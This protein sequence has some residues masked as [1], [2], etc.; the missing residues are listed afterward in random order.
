MILAIGTGRSALAAL[1]LAILVSILWAPM[2]A[3]GALYPTFPIQ[4]SVIVAGQEMRLEWRDDGSSPRLDA[5][6][7]LTVNLFVRNDANLVSTL[8]VGIDPCD[9]V[10]LVEV[11][12]Y[13]GTDGD[14]YYIRYDPSN[15]QA[16]IYTANFRIEGL[17]GSPDY[18]Q[19]RGYQSSGDEGGDFGDTDGGEEDGD[20][21]NSNDGWAGKPYEGV[22]GYDGP[23]QNSTSNAA[24]TAP[25]TTSLA[26][27][28]ASSY[29]ARVSAATATFQAK[30][31][32]AAGRYSRPVSV[33]WVGLTSMI[34]AAHL[35]W[36]F[37]MGAVLAL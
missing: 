33:E 19:N 20:D 3:R 23:I 25:S 17:A 1:N 5:L 26:S 10:A 14:D 24:T 21:S 31:A 18:R 37:V 12:K 15:G 27:T 32:A 28:S 6:D 4:S 34:S 16:P 29:S 13:F 8:A 11:E 7:A 2:L 30:N 22:L 36:P 9:L 35:F